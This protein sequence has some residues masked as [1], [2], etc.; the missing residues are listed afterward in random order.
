MILSYSG[1]NFKHAES[2]NADCKNVLIRGY[3][4]ENF[5]LKKRTIKSAL[6]DQ[7]NN[8]KKLQSCKHFKL[9]GL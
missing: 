2:E 4:S 9:R 5:L 6:C 8:F 3:D 1:I 7:N